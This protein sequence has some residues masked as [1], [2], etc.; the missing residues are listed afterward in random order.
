MKDPT[1]DAAFFLLIF[2]AV[3]MAI[4]TWLCY[5]KANHVEPPNAVVC[6]FPARSTVREDGAIIAKE[7]TGKLTVIIGGRTYTGTLTIPDS[8]VTRTGISSAKT[9]ACVAKGTLR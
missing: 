8:V 6:E 9:A 1:R 2:V 7:M 3:A 4:L 5:S